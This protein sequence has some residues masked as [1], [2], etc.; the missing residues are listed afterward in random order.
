MR[1]GEPPG[2]QFEESQFIKRYTGQRVAGAWRPTTEKYEGLYVWARRFRIRGQLHEA[3]GL[4]YT[5]HRACTACAN[6][7]P[8]HVLNWWVMAS[9][10]DESDKEQPWGFVSAACLFSP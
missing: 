1:H 7:N 4:K 8:Y 9:S 10:I 5:P 3:K 2:P 6:I